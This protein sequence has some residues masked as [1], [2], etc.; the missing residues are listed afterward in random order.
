MSHLLSDIRFA[1][2][3]LRRQPAINGLAMLTLAVGCAAGA[4]VFTAI[5]SLLLRELPVHQPQAVVRMAVI[6]GR[7]HRVRTTFSFAEFVRASETGEAVEGWLGTE[8]FA[9]TVRTPLGVEQ[10]TSGEIVSANYFS[11]LGVPVSAGR[12]FT[13]AETVPNA[14]SRVVMVSDPF[15]RATLRADPQAIGRTIELNGM[16]FEVIGVVGA[17]FRGTNFAAAHDLWVPFGAWL[18]T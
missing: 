15:W 4:T 14:R 10:L 16:P 2:R 11:L 8:A 13:D 1:L 9:T 3:L 12:E 5:H 6:G 17:P 7:G 18:E